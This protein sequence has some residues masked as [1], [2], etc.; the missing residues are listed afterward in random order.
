[1]ADVAR[2]ASTPERE[3]S[4]QWLRSSFVLRG[5]FFMT[6]D[7]VAATRAAAARTIKRTGGPILEV[8]IG[9]ISGFVVAVVVGLVALFVARSFWPSK[10]SVSTWHYALNALP[11]ALLGAAV[12][13]LLFLI[14][15][16]VYS[17]VLA[18][19]KVGNSMAVMLGF[20][21]LAFF[22]ADSW[23]AAGAIDWWRLI[24]LI[25]VISLVGF[26]VLYRKSFRAVS[27]L[28]KGPISTKGVAESDK[29]PQLVKDMVVKAGPEL[30]KPEKIP[31][32]AQVNLQFNAAILLALRILSSGI[33]VAAALFLLGMII[34]SHKSTLDLMSLKKDSNIVPGFHNTFAMGK[35][36]YFWSESLLKVS[37]LLGAIAAAYFV[38]ANPAPDKSENKDKS[39]D[40]VVLEF[41]RKMIILWAF[42]HCL[43]ES[44]H[45]PEIAAE[46]ETAA[47]SSTPSG[48]A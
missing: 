36:Q 2:Q 8:I 38:F 33:I 13:T 26:A 37:L 31:R 1:M 44:A 34:I 29:D 7:P 42:E 3:K 23:R 48:I 43:T 4:L 41:I 15:R 9:A 14:V 40:R 24:T 35:Y 32:R 30:P 20:V 11:Y 19:A 12:A 10:F 46:T 47:S 25:V 16:V 22:T 28:L 6:D 27:D 18:W 17:T 45:E 39:E 5:L 21:V